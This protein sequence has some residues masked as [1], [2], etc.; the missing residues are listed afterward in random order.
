MLNKDCLFCKMIKG[1]IPVN[2][3]YEDDD[4]IIIND[5]NPVAPV[6]M[7]LLIKSHVHYLSDASVDECNMLAKCLKKLGSMSKKLGL[8]DGYRLVVNQGKNAGQTVPHIHVHILAG[9][10]MGWHPAD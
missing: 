10:E 1:D 2:K 9:K 7:L 3:V 8:T 5:I 4:M 6:H